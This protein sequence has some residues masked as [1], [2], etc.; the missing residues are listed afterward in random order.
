MR[1]LLAALLLT[2]LLAVA[3]TAAGPETLF[4]NVVS[5]RSLGC[6]PD[7]FTQPDLRVTV[8]VNGAVVLQTVEAQ[9]ESSPL[10]AN[11]T[12]VQVALPAVVGVEVEEGEPGGFLGLGT[13]W[14]PCDAAPGD[15]AR[16]NVTVEGATQ[17]IVARGDGDN[18]A[19]AVVVVGRDAPAVPTLRLASATKDAATLAWSGDAN[20]TGHRVARPLY[21]GVLGE[22]GPG[23]ATATFTGLC[24][25]AVYA[26]RVVR[27][28]GPWS[29]TSRDLVFRTANVAPQPTRVLVAERAEGNVSNVSWESATTHDVRA[30]EVHMSSSPAF[31]PNASTLRAT[32]TPGP[33]LT[34]RFEARAVSLRAGDAYVLVRTVDTGDLNATSD[35]V[36]FD[37]QQDG[38]LAFAEDCSALGAATIAGG[39]LP[40]TPPTKTTNATTTTTTTPTTS[41]TTTT[42]VP[43]QDTTAPSTKTEAPA[44]ASVEGSSGLGGIAWPYVVA[45]GLGAAALGGVIVLAMRR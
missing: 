8:Y 1:V 35:A 25:N 38:A 29:V 10:F 31:A 7:S 16:Y 26:A 18:A 33:G 4:L 21:R 43:T 36:A 22:A 42:T 14:V 45:I 40:P 39:A 6:S 5:A 23:D 15:G 12:S 9:D 3:A 27:D 28:Q 17:R 13:S 41:T 34:P 2:P 30:F 11:L 24:D 44:P 19:E 32:V 20:A 37:L